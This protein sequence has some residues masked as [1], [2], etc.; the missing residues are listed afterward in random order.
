MRRMPATMRAYAT[1]PAAKSNVLLYGALGAGVLGAGYYASQYVADEKVEVVVKAVDYQKVYNAIAEVLDSED[2]DDGSYG[3]VLV[4]LAWHCSGTYDKNSGDGGSNGAT[5]R[6]PAE[7]NHGCNAGLGAARDKLQPIKDQFPGISYS[8]LWTL[9]GVVAVQE[10]GGPSIP[11]RSGRVD[12][13]AEDCT[14]DGRLPDGDKGSDH[15]RHIFYKM[16]FGD[17][18]I[19]ALSGAHALGR[20]HTDRSGFEGPW[21]FSPTTFTND[22]F[23][24]LYNEKW[25]F[26]K[27]AGPIQ[28][29]NKST[30]SLMMLTTD[31]ALTTDKAFKVFSKLYAKDENKFFDDFSAAYAKL[32]E[33]GVP[34]TQF[35]EAVKLVRTEDQPKIAA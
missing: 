2:Y 30:K 31:M 9:A 29:E 33:L 15:L 35:S 6:F 16:G 11:W 7:G 1:A 26:R 12:G 34:V 4:R 14:S 22:Y 3:P 32:L 21:S 19:V 28:Y 17:Q 5:M 27:W 10:M 18:E 23:K 13:K 20:C 25:S 24:L 8:D